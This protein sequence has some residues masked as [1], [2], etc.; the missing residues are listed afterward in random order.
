[1]EYLH[2]GLAAL[3]A[4][5]AVVGAAIGVGKIGGS[6]MDAIARQPEASGKIQTA[7]IIAAALVEGV[8]LF[9]V[10]AALLGVLTTPA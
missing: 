4:G 6:A 9:G 10:V 5:L 3:G 2:I 1:M 7:M 8:A